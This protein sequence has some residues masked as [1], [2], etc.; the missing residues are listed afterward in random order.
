MPCLLY[1]FSI[2]INLCLYCVLLVHYRC[3]CNNITDCSQRR[4]EKSVKIITEAAIDILGCVKTFIYYFHLLHYCCRLSNSRFFFY[5]NRGRN[6]CKNKI[7]IMEF[8]IWILLSSR[9]VAVWR[10]QDVG[11]IKLSGECLLLS[12]TVV[13]HFFVS[14]IARELVPDLV[15]ACS[16]LQRCSVTAWFN[17]FESQ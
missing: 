9:P 13:R 3:F 12:S 16:D 2:F 1:I 17:N 7:K 6:H 11:A 10:C 5:A 4:F 15:F 14:L 8:V